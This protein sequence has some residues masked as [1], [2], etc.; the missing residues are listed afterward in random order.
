[1]GRNVG[2]R[3]ALR[4]TLITQFFQHERITTTRAKAEAI[5]GAAEHMITQAKRSLAHEDP[6][7]AIHVRRLLHGRLND[8]AIVKKVFDVLAPRYAGRPGGYTR[9]YKL[10]PR[11]GD[12]A[13][14]VILELVDRVQEGEAGQQTGVA[15]AARNLIGRVRG[16]RR[17]RTTP[18]TGA[19]SSTTGTS[20]ESSSESGTAQ[21]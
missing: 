5:R 16:G 11:K 13:E 10:G 18:A 2:Q 6:Q 8:P 7:R 9:L 21:S 17:H 12:A 19:S 14:M 3:N 1:L 4:R 20:G 15:G